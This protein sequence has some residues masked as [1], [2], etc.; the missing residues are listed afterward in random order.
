MVKKKLVRAGVYTLL[1][2]AA[3][4]LLGFYLDILR[5]GIVAD[6]T[7]KAALDVEEFTLMQQY[8]ERNAQNRC[9]IQQQVLND[10]AGQTEELGTR[11]QTYGSANIFKDD[12]FKY[13]TRKYYLS[14]VRYWMLVED[15]RTE[16]NANV[17]TILFFFTQDDA[18][19]QKQGSVLTE[20]RENMENPQVFVFS[21]NT[22]FK[23]ASIVDL[24]E[25]DYNVTEPPALVVNSDTIRKGF[26]NRETV[27]R[28]VTA[29]HSQ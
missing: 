28:L 5:I 8:L 17:S 9:G 15:L 16:C 26:Q 20:V 25:S 12:E 7:D 3:G 6:R 21:F 19:S 29:N 2:F 10:V 11:L 24:L 1:I 22:G 4:L 23:N 27:R 13:L 14:E 18:D